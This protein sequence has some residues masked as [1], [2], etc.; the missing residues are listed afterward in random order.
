MDISLH[1]HTR[2][3]TWVDS[4]KGKFNSFSKLVVS[5]PCEPRKTLALHS[6]TNGASAWLNICHRFTMLLQ[7]SYLDVLVLLDTVPWFRV[8][9]AVNED[10]RMCPKKVHCKDES[11]Q[12][13]C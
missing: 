11:R 13:I 2:V 1:M 3:V 9:L 10:F 6:K 12:S 5:C 8:V 7:L 4:I